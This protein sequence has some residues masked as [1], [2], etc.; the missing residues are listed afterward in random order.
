MIMLFAT[1]MTGVW[2][3]DTKRRHILLFGLGFATFAAGL[4]IQVL[5]PFPSLNGAV[6]A[7]TALYLLAG[8]FS[9]K[10]S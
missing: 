7:A 1:T 3:L 8:L 9:V 4:L 5:H 10:L 6:F 2:V